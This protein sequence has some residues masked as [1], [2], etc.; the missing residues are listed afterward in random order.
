MFY[1]RGAGKL[2]TASAVLGDLIDE[3]KQTDTVLSQ[4]WEPADG[5]TDF[6]ASIDA[7]YAPR[8]YRTSPC[9]SGVFAKIAEEIGVK[10]LGAVENGCMISTCDQKTAEAFKQRLAREGVTILSRI[11]VMED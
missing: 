3:V 2:P 1:G 11:P 9:G 7:F 10:L 5:N 4:S 8:C 6:V